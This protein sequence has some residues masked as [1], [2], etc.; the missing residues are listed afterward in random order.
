MVK[1]IQVPQERLEDT[2][3]AYIKFSCQATAAQITAVRMWSEA[4]RLSETACTPLNILAKTV[5][6]LGRL[7]QK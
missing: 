2:F 3:L 1:G 7:A 4:N 5:K 6:P